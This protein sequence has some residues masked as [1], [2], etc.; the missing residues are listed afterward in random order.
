M[1]GTLGQHPKNHSK[2]GRACRRCGNQCAIV[3]KY[4]LNL[5]RQCFRETAQAIGFKKY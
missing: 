4:Q 5:C 2:G 3:R 1:A